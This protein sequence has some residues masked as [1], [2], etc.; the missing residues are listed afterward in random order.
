M[1]IRRWNRLLN[2]YSGILLF[3]FS[4]THT[5][6]GSNPNPEDSCKY[7]SVKSLQ[8]IAITSGT[9]EKPQSKVWFHDKNWWAVLPDKN[10]TELWQLL[11]TRWKS[12]LHL[13]DSTNTMADALSCENV[14]H[15]LLFHGCESALVS[16]EYDLKKRRYQPW[17]KR[18]G[19]VKIPLERVSETATIDIDRSGRMWIASDDKTEVHVRWSDS[20]YEVWSKPQTL[21]TGITNDDICAVTS[22][23]DGSIGVMWSNQN[24]R[25]FGFRTHS[26]DT[27]PGNWSDD[28]I[29]ASDSAI[30]WKDGMADD[31]LN[32]AVASDGTLYAAV[33]TS[34]D[35]KGYPLVALLVRRPPGR[36]DK[37]YNVDD[38]GSR[39]IVL[40]NEQEES[41]MIV[42]TSYRDHQIVCKRSG[43]KTISFGERQI[44]MNAVHEQK[45]IN[46]ATSTKQKITGE[47]VIVASEPG[48]ARSVLLK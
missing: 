14:T 41:L 1:I 29:P 39:G 21:A 28:E 47:V 40:L 42:Y 30:P 9:G 15:I 48:I 46:N 4:V 17:P 23:P 20:P 13:S 10:G 36:W 35:T 16:V 44:L 12:V 37:L 26:P 25:R 18:P 34:Y 2:R 7:L 38:E 11:N 31:H 5:M 3:I 27:D 19:K 45:S 6:Y 24:T 32:I 33:K 8:E 22:L 43:T